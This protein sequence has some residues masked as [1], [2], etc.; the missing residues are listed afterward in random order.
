MKTVILKENAFINGRNRVKG[1]VVTVADTFSLPR[2][3]L[4][5]NYGQ[6]IKQEHSNNKNKKDAGLPDTLGINNP[7]G[8]GNGEGNGHQP[9]VSGG[10]QQSATEGVGDQNVVN[11][12][13]DNDRPSK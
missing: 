13:P 2:I 9:V 4:Q 3:T 10:Q 8:G 11:G 5:R 6:E 1:E 12:R 7:V